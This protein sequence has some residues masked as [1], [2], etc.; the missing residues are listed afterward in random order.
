MLTFGSLFAGIGGFD[1]GFERAGMKCTWQVECDPFCHQVLR[2]HWPNGRIWDDVRTF[3][4]QPESDWRV[5]LLCGGFPCQDISTANPGRKGLAGARSGLWSEFR[6]VIR[7]LGPRIVVVEN[8]SNLAVLGLDQVL[9][10]LSELGFDAE[11]TTIPASY[12][13]APQSR[14]RMFVVAYSMC[15]R[16]PLVLRGEPR[17]CRPSDAWGEWKPRASHSPCSVLQAVEESVGQPSVL[18]SRDGISAAVDRLR[19]LGNAVVPQVA[20][21]IGRRIVECLC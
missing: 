16:R 2:K 13:G 4:P 10:D 12:V 14:R 11:W 5:D 9:G 6:R 3:P 8:V 7:V 15:E 20:E 1:L 17:S 19:V 18:G 21:L